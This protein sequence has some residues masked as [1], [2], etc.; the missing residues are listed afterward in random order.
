[1]IVMN[2]INEQQ[3]GRLITAT[4]KATRTSLKGLNIHT[5]TPEDMEN[6]LLVW[7]AEN[8]TLL[9]YLSKEGQKY[10]NFIFV[11]L[12]RQANKIKVKE[13]EGLENVIITDDLE[14]QTDGGVRAEARADVSRETIRTIMGRI[15]DGEN[16]SQIE[17]RVIASIVAHSLGYM[18]TEQILLLELLH[19]KAP[20]EEIK[21]RTGIS[22]PKPRRLELE[23]KVIRACR[24]LL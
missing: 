21:E 14:M 4:K 2:L 1:M 17:P 18:K 8:L 16:V 24:G 12:L 22:H 6:E 9:T 3:W 15:F 23:A 5:L 10:D 13:L 11:S 19:R 20:L 7:A